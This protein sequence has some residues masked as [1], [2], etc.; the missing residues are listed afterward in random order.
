MNLE[1]LAHCNTP[2]ENVTLK[3]QKYFAWIHEQLSASSY[4]CS[5]ECAVVIS[6]KPLQQQKCILNLKFSSFES[7]VLKNYNSVFVKF[8]SGFRPSLGKE[9]CPFIN[10]TNDTKVGMLVL[11][12]TSRGQAKPLQRSLIK[13]IYSNA[14]HTLKGASSTMSPP[15]VHHW[16]AVGVPEWL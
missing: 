10:N 14:T 15:L 6:V 13:H 8:C 3:F 2:T 11:L 5:T 4:N 16:Y 7:T 1:F 12:T 9:L